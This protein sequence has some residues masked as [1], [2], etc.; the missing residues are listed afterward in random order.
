VTRRLP[1]RIAA[2]LRV[3]YDA[4]LNI[5]DTPWTPADFARAWDAADA[6]VCTVSDRIDA[7]VLPTAP[8]RT[9][10]LANFGVGINHIA[11]DA[12]AAAG[13]TVTN[14]PDVLTDDT[15]DLAIALMLGV[16]RRLTE[17]ERELRE[18]RWTGWRPTHHLGRRLTG[19]T[20][21]IVGYGR[22]G[23]AVAHRAHFGF[24]M[25]VQWY[26]PRP[27]RADGPL[28]G[29]RADSLEALLGSC[30]VISLH[31]PASPETHHLI[32]GA[33]LRQMKPGAVLINTA[34]GD[35]VDEAALIAALT[36][37]TLSAAGL[38]VYEREPT[39]PRALLELPNVVLLP[40]LGSATIESREA[41][42][43]RVLA[44]LAA[45]FSGQ[46]LPDRVSGPPL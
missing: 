15:A 36:D 42:G 32:D 20:L 41:M 10:L 34:R 4:E 11:R 17:G 46:S 28:L 14:T 29:R 45:F 25:P 38:D 2:A 7:A 27:P 19:R 24:G 33:R 31:C 18:G 40:H 37:G 3:A 43:E 12:A 5:D 8:V 6:V 22:I 21:G 44:N 39:V 9:K 23:Q 35:V 16:L 26:A 1:A 30:D 13:I